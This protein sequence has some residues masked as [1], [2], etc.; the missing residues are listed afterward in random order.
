MDINI[1]GA[2]KDTFQGGVEVK[3][4]KRSRWPIFLAGTV[5]GILVVTGVTYYKYPQIFT[6]R[7]PEE[8]AKIAAGVLVKEVGKIMILPT[9]EDPTILEI[10]DPQSLISQQP[11][12]TG[13]IAGDKLLVYKQSA[14]A[15]VYSPSRHLIVNVGPVTSEQTAA[16][17]QQPQTTT[18]AT[19]KK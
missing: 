17:T 9:N 15:I 16:T 19:K 6:L 4:K 10:T 2:P 13:A 1:D 11:F 5:F 18:T 12:F 14:R 8:Q 3:S 7:T